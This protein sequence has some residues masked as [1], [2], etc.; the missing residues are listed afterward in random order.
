MQNGT[1]RCGIYIGDFELEIDGWEIE[2][3][4]PNAEKG[5]DETQ[6]VE[7]QKDIVRDLTPQGQGKC[8]TLLEF[9]SHLPVPLSLGAM[10]DSPN[11]EEEEEVVKVPALAT[12]SKASP[13]KTGKP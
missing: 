5:K 2:E 6:T 8:A 11:G 9:P 1:W 10:V 4:T 13:P 3:M 12:T 7:Q